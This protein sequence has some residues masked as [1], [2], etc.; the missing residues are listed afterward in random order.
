MAGAI[1]ELLDAPERRAE[2]GRAGRRY[3]E[4]HHSRAVIAAQLEEMLGEVTSG[5]PHGPA[6]AGA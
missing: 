4:E 2:M 1:R 6:T 3:I 5:L